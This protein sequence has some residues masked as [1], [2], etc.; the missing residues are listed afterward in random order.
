MPTNRPFTGPPPATKAF[1]ITL[2]AD[3]P[4]CLSRQGVM[5]KAQLSYK[6][7][8]E[9]LADYDIVVVLGGGIDGVLK[10][11]A[12]P[13]GLIKAY[14]DMQEESPTQE[15]TLMSICTGSLLLAQQGLLLGLKAT[16]HPDYIVRLENLCSQA[17]VREL[18]ERTD[19]L[20]DVRYVVNNLRFDVGEKDEN[21]YVYK[22]GE[23]RKPVGR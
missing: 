7:A 2:V 12:E 20:E 9:N 11:G 14:A 13:L 21:P 19:V 5:V 17:A 8:Y 3:E 23:G 1:E 22:K 18:D 15:R 6:E 10:A 4:A 16:T